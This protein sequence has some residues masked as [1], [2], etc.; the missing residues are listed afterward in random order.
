MRAR[1]RAR[2]LPPFAAAA[3][4]NWQKMVPKTRSKMHRLDC[5]AIART[6]ATMIIERGLRFSCARAHLFGDDNNREI[7]RLHACFCL[8][9]K[10]KF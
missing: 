7:A 9:L 10:Q 8:H 2:R 1:V 6:T 3:A 4:K 5:E